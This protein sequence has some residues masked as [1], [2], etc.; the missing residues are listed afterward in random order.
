MKRFLALCLALVVTLSGCS[1][2]SSQSSSFTGFT[3][4]L[5]VNEVSSDNITLNFTLSHP[6]TYSIA[7]AATP[8]GSYDYDS[9]LSSVAAS[10]NTLARCNEFS[11]SQ[12]PIHQKIL[13][14]TLKNTLQDSVKS[15]KYILH[16]RS[17]SP[18]LGVQSQFPVLLCEYPLRKFEDI[19]KY[20]EILK[21][22]PD[23]FSSMTTFEE[24]RIKKGYGMPKCAL[25][26]A[27]KSCQSFMS[28]ESDNLLITHFNQ[29]IDEL[30]FLTA[31][32]INYAKKKNRELV[33][34]CVIPA[35][36]KLSVSLNKWKKKASEQGNMC[37]LPNGKDYYQFAM[38]HS[39]G[40]D[41]TIS[42]AKVL[43]LDSYKSSRQKLLS[44]AAKNPGLMSR[45][46]SYAIC[47]KEPDKIIKTLKKACKK[48]FPKIKDRKV[49]IKYVSPELESY[50]SPAFYLTAPL[51]D[52]DQNTIYINGS[53]QYENSDLFS[54]LAHEGYPGHMFQTVFHNSHLTSPLEGILSYE[55]YA[56]GWASYC[57]IYSFNY[58]GLPQD[59]IT[60]L[61]ENTLSSLCLN[62]LCDIGIHYDGW[63]RD[64]T[65]E[66]LIQNGVVSTASVNALYDEIISNPGN[67]LKYSLGNLEMD[68]LKSAAKQT[69]KD[70]YSDL[71]FHTY[72]LTVG[73][74]SFPILKSY[75]ENVSLIN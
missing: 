39:V 3:T 55:G 23:Y 15:G 18:N 69:W 60:V 66:F 24:L 7:T 43:L 5:F 62:A 35:Y 41:L 25:D 6:E 54:T 67:Y 72:V 36:A 28:K 31:S 11:K 68:R 2:A 34:S 10:E 4:S 42:K 52:L 48:D 71:K 13:L 21:A 51:D 53:T 1:G 38:Q 61:K 30:N 12:L 64:K 57:E 27:L 70:S 75:L 73:P 22:V 59:V 9:M 56:E 8:L 17:F 47:S 50:L 32:E 74:T 14:D 37:L 49:Q 33:L 16:N 19:D 20:F 63:S 44:L 46:S 26:G 45:C 40:T 65:K 58:S 29:R